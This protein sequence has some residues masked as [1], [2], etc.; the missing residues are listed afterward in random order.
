MRFTSLGEVN[1]VDSILKEIQAQAQ[2]SNQYSDLSP[3]FLILT[4]YIASEHFLP[5]TCMVPLLP[6]TVAIGQASA[7]RHSFCSSLGEYE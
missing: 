3:T 4:G 2:L 7:H 5:L 1:K 6:Y